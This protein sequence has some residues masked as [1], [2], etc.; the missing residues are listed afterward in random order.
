[1]LFASDDSASY[2]QD[3]CDSVYASNVRLRLGET[4]AILR[5]PSRGRAVAARLVVL[6]TGASDSTARAI[7]DPVVAAL[8]V[9]LV[10]QGLYRVP[11]ASTK[12]ATKTAVRAIQRR[13]NLI[14]DGV[15][16]A[17]TMSPPRHISCNRSRRFAQPSVVQR[18]PPFGC[19][20]HSARS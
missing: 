19:R 2:R 18:P 1:M 14:S 8:Q 11:T 20:T 3:A 5:S 4:D 10:Q 12:R 17:Q 13:H 16:G 9:A 7:G 15:A 6:V